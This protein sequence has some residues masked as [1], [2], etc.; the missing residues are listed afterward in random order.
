MATRYFN[1]KLAT[2]L[3]V[4]IV[5]FAVAA[6]A[7]HQW[8]KNT[9]AVRSLSLGEAAYAKQDWDEAAIQLGNYI[10]VDREKVDVL[11]KYADAQLK[12]QP[13]SLNNVRLAVD[14]YRSV[15]HLDGRNVE[16]ARR[17]IEVYLW[18][19]VG[20]PV[21][22]NM[23]A[24]NYLKSNDDAGIR[25]MHAQALYLLRKPEG[26]AEELKKNL[27]QHPDDVQSY[28]MM[29]NLAKSSPDVV[30]KPAA[31]WFDDAVAKNPQAALA[32]IA[33]AGFY[34]PSDRDKALA[35]LEQAQKC[36][37]PDTETRGRLVGGLMDARLLDQ[38]KE[39]LKT[40]RLL[41]QA[42]EQLRAWQAK[43]PTEPELWKYWAN[44]ASVANSLALRTNDQAA[45]AKS[46]EEMYTVAETGLK[47]LA[48]QPWDFMPAATE[49]LVRSG[50]I[51]EAKDCIAQMRQKGIDSSVTA[52][53]E[54]LV[55]EKQGQLRDAITDWRKAITLGYRLPMT[56][57]MRLADALSR[58]GDTQ[59]AIGEVRILVSDAPSDVSRRLNLAQLLAQVKDWP[60]VQDQALQIL[61][62]SPR[63]AEAVQLELQ[64]RMHL[65][66]ANT[67]PA[68]EREKAW[69]EIETQLAELDKANKGP[70]AIEIELLQAQVALI[71]KKLPEAASMLTDLE[72]KYPSEV[73]V[74]VLQ[75]ELCAAQDKKEEAKTRLQA[76]VAKFP[77]ALEPV[78]TLALFLDRQNQHQECEAVIQ[79]GL[80]RIQDPRLRR[81]LGLDLAQFYWQWK[82]E[83]KLT[84][85]L[86]DMAGQFPSDIQPR[87]LLLTCPEIVK[88]PGK[89]QSIIDEIKSLEGDGGGQWRYEQARL[90]NRSSADEFKT[91]YPQIVKLLRENLVTNPK[92]HLSRLLL[93]DTYER[94]N[95][96]PL[97]V[98]TYREELGLLPNSVPIRVRTI[99]ALN[100]VKE[101][102]KARDLLDE[103][104]Q[105]NLHDPDLEKL[106]LQDDL[107]RGN[108]ISAENI[109]EKM[110]SQDPN[111]TTSSLR[112]VR[113]HVQLKKYDEAQ[114]ILDSLKVKMPDSAAVTTAQI[115]LYTQRG[116]AE[117]AI[118]L[119]DQT[120]DKL[121]SAS[122]YLLRARTYI[123]LGQNGK[124]LEDFG[125][126][127]TLEPGKAE[128]WA[129]RADFYRAIGRIGEGISDV[130]HALALSP[131]SSAMQRLAVLLFIAS[132]DMPRIG[133]AEAILDKALAT[134]EKAPAPNP[135]PTPSTSVGQGS[136]SGTEDSQLDEYTQFRLLKARVLMLKGTGPGIEGARRILRE[137][138]NSQPKLAE[139]WQW[140]TQLE[141]SQ[142]DYGRAS[143]VALQ[144]LAYNKGNGWLLLL[145]ARA[146]K[147][148]SPSMAAWTL[149]GLQEQSPKN[150]EILVELADAYARAGRAKEA[151]DLLR[152]KMEELERPEDRRRCDIAYAE[153][154]YA[155]GQREEAKTR[156][157]TLTQAEPNDPTPTMTL[158]QQLRREKRWTEMNQLVRGWLATHPNGANVATNIAGVLATTG[159]TQALQVGEDILRMTL[160]RNPQSKQALMLLSMMMQDAGRNE[161]SAKLDRKILEV[162]PNNLIAMNNL[163]WILCDGEHPLDQYKE[164]LALTERAL[165]IVPEDYVDLL[166][167]RGYVYYRLGDFDK[168]VSSFVKCTELYPTNSPSAATPRFHLAMTYAAMKRKTEAVQQL[169]TALDSN[170]ANLRLAKE[171]ADGGRVTYVIKVLKDAL[172]LQEQMEPLKATLGLAGYA[173]SPSPQEVA[174]A[175]ALLDRLQKG[176]Y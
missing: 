127:I 105:Q 13:L 156:F 112:L 111:D 53:L 154:L 122:A 163:A 12:R 60:E 125:R 21:D 87:R 92:D 17:L 101:F 165:K 153:A 29:G 152:Q 23:V 129:A 89:A 54:G 102:D 38:A 133:E 120:V 43:D 110:V 124:A 130:K 67:G 172:T 56:V 47:A 170:R 61:K 114:K 42:R 84:K 22:A 73:R 155:N 171:Q 166:D 94:A 75:A 82:E 174:D 72:S 176:N 99:L 90:W 164:A 104:D 113:A 50:H 24:A 123:A 57:H 25:R 116:K 121:R 59:S 144:G 97:A 148:R 64:A 78:R 30:S 70:L 80:A 109:L 86:S 41:D 134:F 46:L 143:D 115:D 28:E 1:W 137:I 58:L 139:P 118:R 142:E 31:A 131:D 160:D 2:V 45:Q 36:D 175:K 6:Y 26:A 107:R 51:E 34:L 27:D 55:A 9:R 96:L 68:A 40:A 169:Q 150:V 95:D 100:K 128:S 93:A 19:S 162:D 15:L 20:A 18:P 3:M 63:Y 146:E 145:K 132:R 48:A 65:L 74:M 106:R 7:L 10:G 159:D 138:T 76:A 44:L 98:T 117:E 32:Y 85:W 157:D 151:V 108:W 39:Q 149:K 79:E 167:T 173:G 69:Q 136:S 35:D 81:E 16:A 91:R 161:E 5:V 126:V 168:A 66:A 135:A 103:A 8:Q 37:L 52:F 158:A 88:D 141:L 11:A 33:R 119:C 49:L 147:V 83:D 77:Q 71:R 62:L 4:A 14:A 140:L